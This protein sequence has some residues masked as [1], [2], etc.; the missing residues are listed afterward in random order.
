MMN[1]EY[2]GGW[3]LP[4]HG[5]DVVQSLVN[6]DRGEGGTCREIGVRIPLPT[7]NSLIL[8]QKKWWTQTHLLPINPPNR[9]FSK[10]RSKRLVRNRR[11]RKHLHDV[12]CHSVP[13]DIGLV[14]DR[15]EFGLDTGLGGCEDCSGECEGVVEFE[16][17]VEEGGGCGCEERYVEVDVVDL[18][19]GGGL[20]EVEE[21]DGCEWEGSGDNDRVVGCD[22]VF[23]GDQVFLGDF[24]N[25]RNLNSDLDIRHHTFLLVRTSEPSFK[26]APLFAKRPSKILKFPGLALFAV[27]AARL[28]IPA[29]ASIASASWP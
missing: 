29:T 16:V 2:G 12:L 26:V 27:D 19:E 5:V 1:E 13:G 11:F 10:Q 25:R 20:R 18:G 28:A 7:T 24:C 8:F 15:V 23:G 3:D 21:L 9:A 6:L 4:F 14:S 17:G 22:R